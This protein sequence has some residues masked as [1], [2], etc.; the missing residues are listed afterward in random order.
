MKKIKSLDQIILFLSTSS[1]KMK[2][3]SDFESDEYKI[4]KSLK[5]VRFVIHRDN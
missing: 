2:Q 4:N 1:V 5:G 3:S